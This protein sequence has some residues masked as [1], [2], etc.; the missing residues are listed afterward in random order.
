MA[1][2]S[3][4]S[5][6]LKNDT[7][8]SNTDKITND[9]TLNAVTALKKGDS[10]QY[11]VQKFDSA[12]STWSTVSSWGASYAK[13]T[14]SGTYKILVQE[15]NNK[16]L[17]V[18]T[19]LPGELTF[20]LDVSTPAAPGAV[21]ALDSGIAGD[22]YTNSGL[23]THPNI[24]QGA[25]IEYSINGGTSWNKTF[26]A[27]EGVNNILV[28]QTD[29]AGNV[30]TNSSLSFTL[31]TKVAALGVALTQDTG[32]SAA[33]LYTSNGAVTVTGIESGATVY[34]NNNNQG[35]TS[36]F[37]AVEGANNL[38]IHQIDKAGN[39][40]TS[41][42]LTFT[43]D[44]QAANPTIALI[45]DSGDS[46]DNYTNTGALALGGIESGATAQYSANGTSWTSGFNAQE[47]INTVQVRQIDK[48][49]N[50][51][52]SSSLTFTL[53]TQVSTPGVALTQDSGSNNTDRYTNNGALTVTGLEQGGSAQ[54]SLDNGA[55]WNNSF[56]ASQGINNVLVRQVDKAGNISTS[57]AFSFTLDNQAS[58]PSIALSV[59]SGASDSDKYTNNGALTVTG[60]EFGATVQYSTNGGVT[61]SSKFTPQIGVN[62]V[63]VRQ[64]D[65]A[66]NIS[67]SSSLKFTLDTI[68]PTAKVTAISTL[69][70][71]T[72][73]G[74]S[75]N[76]FIT[77]VAG[78]TITGS[79]SGTLAANEI[80]QIS[81]DAGVTWIDATILD[82]SHWQASGVI[83]HEGT[84]TLVTRTLD[85]A[86][87]STT[88]VLH[89]YTLDTTPPA[90]IGSIDSFSADSAGPGGTGN[91]FITNVAVQ[92]ISGTYAG[93][94]NADENIMISVDGGDT[95]LTANI[96]DNTHWQLVGVALKPDTNLLIAQSSDVAGNTGAEASQVY[97]L[98]TTVA[99]P[100]VSLFNDTSN[101]DAISSDGRLMIADVEQG[102]L[103]EY[104]TDNGANWV[105]DFFA[106]EG[107]NSVRVRQI[108]VAGNTS[109]ET[110]FSFTLDTQVT[111]PVVALA[112]DTSGGLGITSDG[113][114][115]ITGTETNAII[116][117]SIDNGANWTAGFNATQGVNDVLVRQT[118][119]AGNEART[120]FSF[121]LD[122]LAAAPQVALA[123]DTSGGQNIT[124]DWTLAVTGIEPS[125]TVEYSTDGNDWS[126]AFTAERGLNTVWVRQTDVAGNT[127]AATSFSFTLNTPLNPPV[128]TLQ[129]DSSGGQLVS[130]NGAL[131]VT[132]I[133]TGAAIAY[134]I[135]NGDTWN[136]DF[137]AQEG[138]NVVLVRQS[139][140]AGNEA[141]TQFSFTLDTQVNPLTVSLFNDTSG[142]QLYSN[143]AELVV[144]GNEQ[145]ATVEY[146]TDSGQTWSNAF[147]AQEGLNELL[148]R[149]T[150]VAG[151]VS[152]ST[153]FNFTYDT[154]I[155]API[156]ALANDTSGGLGITS[157]SALDVTGIETG[158][159]I[160]Y[161]ADNGDTWNDSF[162]GQEGLNDILVRQIDQAGN[163]ARTAFSFVLDTAPPS[164]VVSAISALSND[165]FASGTA[166]NDSDFITNTANQSV[167]GSYTGTLD[168]GDGIQVSA[169]GTTWVTAIVDAD[170]HQ[171][172]A[173]GV[174]L[175]DGS[176]MLTTR[177]I[178]G[179]GN[180]LA[181]ATH[182]YTLDTIAPG[183]PVFT[184]TQDTGVSSND[185][186][187]QNVAL[188]GTAEV[189]STVKIY[190]G[191]TLLGSTSAD[192]T[193]QW[194]YTPILADGTYN[195]TATATDTV[196]NIS[197]LGQF[198]APNSGAVLNAANGHYYK[199]VNASTDWG[200]ALAAAAS[201][202]GYLATVTSAQENSF[203][204]SIMDADS[205][206]WLGGSD[207]A[208]QGQWKWVTGPES[209]AFFQ[210]SN[211]FMN[212]PNNYAGTED[213]LSISNASYWTPGTWND[214]PNA[215]YP[216]ALSYIIEFDSNPQGI[217]FDTTAST[218]LTVSGDNNGD[219]VL[220]STERGSMAVNGVVTGVEDG[221]IVTV[222]VNGHDY[223]TTIANGQWTLTGSALDATSA[224]LSNV[225]VNGS[226]ALTA[227]VSDLAGNVATVNA[228]ATVSLGNLIFADNFD[229]RISGTNL[230]GNPVQTSS[231][232]ATNW[233][234]AN[235][236]LDGANT[237][238]DLSGN[239]YIKPSEGHSSSLASLP[240]N[241]GADVYKLTADIFPQA[242]ATVGYLG[243]GFFTVNSGS[244][245]WQ[246]NTTELA[247][248]F[249][250][251][252]GWALVGEAVENSNL[253]AAFL[254]GQVSTTNWSS[255]MPPSVELTWDT[256]HNTVSG[257]INDIALFTDYSLN[258]YAISAPDVHFVGIPRDDKLG[259]SAMID[260]F[261]FWML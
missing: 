16:G 95:W 240:Y 33:D 199:F 260:N 176:H 158:A 48:A 143:D 133:E 86:G 32:I 35:W 229:G 148:A 232:G 225:L 2:T 91:D 109:V 261:E 132:G 10:I 147:T 226:N 236:Y 256:V 248:I 107:D 5:V 49:G 94:L 79:Y 113:T 120:A 4:L 217:T 121:T 257:N 72:A 134:S 239:G 29:V 104:S 173:D 235:L 70:D 244:Y 100:A 52:A 198:N 141:R 110:A 161:S 84:N 221:R 115:A 13:P 75:N 234:S 105:T 197:Q 213:Y 15:V 180:V 102:A 210:Y 204:T 182:S 97:T 212:E 20:T 130:N 106:Q 125:A 55:N 188:T 123:N 174:V 149:Q 152:Y 129:N 136:A 96:V 203:I 168:F 21:L 116:E 208:Q 57:T 101:G 12:T 193:G 87:N 66:G 131:S 98:D 186:I 228:T 51:S 165:S 178:D 195:L 31:D 6:S 171:W 144:T 205:I 177:T 163:E 253:G 227:T 258:G 247:L 58:A 215:G 63:L 124:T 65:Q 117:Y 28:R 128:V 122:T 191:Q 214:A 50:T 138:S 11:Q 18:N 224:S 60:A 145:G 114:L 162:A 80:F 26:T 220:D 68:A 187:T 73:F 246:P 175:Q 59:D 118:D 179:V 142:G 252:G 146:S 74:G 53:D 41:T 77:S 37:V 89:G 160:Q 159:I 202:G 83:L 9:A 157:D 69:S 164:A 42:N 78:Q 170:N 254:S 93:P 25:S 7:G 81:A 54:Y 24:E 172:H 47:G 44:T 192:N 243:L 150:D 218:T 169:D 19:V 85:L 183:A 189:G 127:S 126:N 255:N 71:D 211:W 190:N 140:A 108:D 250:G 56:T 45:N 231:I 233:T 181:G 200:T 61:Y 241:L 137:T 230:N 185:G 119:T 1:T 219:G 30:S 184:L 67:T 88:G 46:A 76:D 153:A 222:S 207:A 166:G 111:G 90:D 43:L 99:A 196:G 223:T 92:T 194:N 251:T 154:Q 112:I 139:D 155:A 38:Q 201:Q 135:D 22:N 103:V 14:T 82:G 249:D 8:V 62:N 206:A 64:I 27:L 39:T 23:L 151:N 259:A 34:Y 17:A 245:I 3:K 40:S 167:S 209:N 242:G 156:V 216:F 238:A 237:F 36:S